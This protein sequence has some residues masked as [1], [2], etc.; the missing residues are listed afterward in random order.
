MRPQFRHLKVLGIAFLLLLIISPGAH[1]QTVAPFMGIGI[2]QWLDNNGAPL[3]NGVLYSYQAGTST[4]QA[5]YVDNSGTTQNPNPIPFGSG[6]R[7]N[8]WLASGQSYKLVLCQQNDGPFCAAGDILAQV[9]NVP[10]GGGGGG[11]GGNCGSTCTGT[12]ISGSASPATSGILRIAS[13]DQICW[14]NASGSTNLCISK[15]SN[16][17]LSWAGG[18]LKFPE[19]PCPAGLA[20]FDVI[21][22]D[23]IA[24]RWKMANNGGPAVQIAAAGVDINASDQVTQLHFGASAAPL[25]ALPATGQSLCWN[26]ANIVGCSPIAVN[27][28][29]LTLRQAVVGPVTLTTPS[30]NGFYRA[31]CYLVV[32]QSASTSST[33]PA[34]T[35]GYTDADSSVPETITLM[36]STSTN[37]LGAIGTFTTPG[38]QPGFFAKSGVAI[39]YSTSGY[40]SSG[41]TPMQYSVHV[42]LEGPF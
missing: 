35:V 18:S 42:R 29:D 14:R 6:A 7:V 16:D 23:V 39:T 41:G 28:S 12:F 1:S 3:V 15:D 38:F 37:G 9:D 17:L 31:T 20:T 25:G 26:G 32:T 36:N 2:T 30:A 24:H 10:G 33:L 19:V 22:A 5:T 21:C 11:I 8:I 13:S 40:A 4:Q 34:C 27:A